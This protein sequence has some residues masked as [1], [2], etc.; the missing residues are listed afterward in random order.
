MLSQRYI[1]F[2]L[3]ILMFRGAVAFQ[4]VPTKT[5][6]MLWPEYCRA[7]LYGEYDLT[8]KM[9]F[10]Y[11][12][13]SREVVTKWKRQ[14]GDAFIHIHHYCAGLVYFDRGKLHS[15]P[16]EKAYWLNRA[17]DETRY[18]YD[19]TSPENPMYARMAVTLARIYNELNRPN[20]SKEYIEKAMA[21]HP[22]YDGSY[23]YVAMVHRKNGHQSKA[24]EVLKQGNEVVSGKSAAIHYFM[25]LIYFD[26]GKYVLA[27]DHAQQAY[28]L[29]Y[30]LPGLKRKLIEVDHWTSP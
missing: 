18:T 28:R 19:R 20:K 10:D 7:R 9:N 3:G 26:N 2:L 21:L 24:L 25:G 13:P 8:S 11:P 29:G 16:K 14:I 1:L 15:E 27:K 30:P 5:E 4:F 23:I 17:K 12:S 22:E 6:W